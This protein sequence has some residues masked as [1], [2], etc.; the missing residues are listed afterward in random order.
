MAGAELPPHDG[1]AKEPDRPVVVDGLAGRAQRWTACLGTSVSYS[2]VVLS[3]PGG[4]GVYLQI[5]QAE[6]VDRTDQVLRGI[7]IE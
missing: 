4:R 6:A 1:C 3:E 2:E 7:R 5:R